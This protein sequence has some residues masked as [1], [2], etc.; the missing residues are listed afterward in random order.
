MPAS[1]SGSTSNVTA[2]GA[3]FDACFAAAM[4]QAGA[5]AAALDLT[6]RLDNEA[7]V[8]ALDEYGGPVAVARVF[9]PFRANEN[10]A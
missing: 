6:R 1:C 9:Y 5:S 2:A 7:N 8:Q 4:A 3:A 10:D